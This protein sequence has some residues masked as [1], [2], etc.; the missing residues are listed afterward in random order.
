MLSY[1]SS[2]RLAAA[3]VVCA[4]SAP[5]F[6]GA[7][8]MSLTVNAGSISKN[9]TLVA[10][11]PT[12]AVGIYNGTLTGAE[13]IWSAFYNLNASSS[14]TM[15]SSEQS[16]ANSWMS[17]SFSISNTTQS[18]VTYFITLSLPTAV[19]SAMSGLFNGSI[20]GTLVTGGA[21]YLRTVGDTSLWTASSGGMTVK[22]LFDA[23]V[24]VNRGSAG[25]TSLGSQS[26]TATSSPMF[27]DNLAT[28]LSFKLSA[29]ATA[30]FTTSFSGIGTP[31]PAPGAVALLGCA[32]LALRRRRR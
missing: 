24:N 28:I 3:A 14:V 21:G 30:S 12:S 27:G 4:V 26:F 11:D 2:A 32:G 18:E 19:T 22:T 8:D 1:A 13:G 9:Q 17:G 6:A 25:A 31:V 15:S 16:G 29:G 5:A 20:S 10:V 23:P 7:P